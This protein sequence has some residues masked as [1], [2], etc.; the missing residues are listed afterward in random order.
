MRLALESGLLLGLFA[1]AACGQDPFLQPPAPRPP[2][3]DYLNKEAWKHAFKDF[4]G[5]S[6]TRP[7]FY[8]IEESRSDVCAVRLL[9]VPLRQNVESWMPQV[10]PPPDGYPT[11]EAQV[12]APACPKG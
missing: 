8:V 10:I 11:V 6:K 4:F 5:K 7:V 1:A 12:P 3:T 9:E 2:K